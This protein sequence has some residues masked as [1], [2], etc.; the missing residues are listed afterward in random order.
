MSD[1]FY[2]RI[3]CYCPLALIPLIK[4]GRDGVH[5]LSEHFA[6]RAIAC[7]LP[8]AHAAN[9]CLQSLTKR[10]MCCKALTTNSFL[11]EPWYSYNVT[12]ASLQ[13]TYYMQIV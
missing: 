6:E 12:A 10:K 9:E 13:Q 11:S 8:S 2:E 7:A 4:P 3:K 1:T 5:L